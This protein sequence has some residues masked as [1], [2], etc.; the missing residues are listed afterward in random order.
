MTQPGVPIPPQPGWWERTNRIG[1]AT[2]GFGWGVHAVGVTPVVGGTFDLHTTISFGLTGAERY[3][4]TFGLSLT[5]GLGMDGAERYTR[6]LALPFT[7]AVAMAGAERYARAFNVPATP[8]IAMTGGSL[9]T[10]AFGLPF[11]PSL[12]MTAAERYAQTVGLAVTPTFGMTG[13]V[14]TGVSYDATSAGGQFTA[15][16]FSTAHTIAGKA[17]IVVVTTY[18]NQVPTITATVGATPMV[19]LYSNYYY[20]SGGNYASIYF[21]G[22]LNP[23]TGAQTISYTSSAGA[24]CTYNVGST[25]YNNAASIGAAQVASSGGGSSLPA[26]TASSAINQIVAQT[27]GGFGA[28]FTGYNQTRRFNSIPTAGYAPFVLGDAPGAAS[29]SFSGTTADIWVG[30]AVALS[31]TAPTYDATGTAYFTTTPTTTINGS[32]THTATAG[33]TVVAGIYTESNAGTVTPTGYTRS[34]TYGGTAMTSQGAIPMNNSNYGWVE[35]FTLAN[36]AGGAQTVAVHATGG[37][38]TFTIVAANSDSYLGVGSIGTAVTNY[39]GGTAMTSGSVPSGPGQLVAQIFGYVY[40]AT[41]TPGPVTAYSGSARY[42]QNNIV[43]TNGWGAMV[44]GDAPGT[45]TT[46]ITATSPTAGGYFSSVAVPLLGK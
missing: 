10:G 17:L 35:I 16:T 32:W 37:T 6:T 31:A 41:L 38:G 43:I 21:F 34:A 4:Q 30:L 42:A 13:T 12:G 20:A 33:A 29:V 23:P 22:V 19:L 14:F 45:P 26:Q 11:T 7:P 39:G 9:S 36:V 28:T 27:F 46:T 18:G 3:A 40:A 44:L 15:A 8:A 1:T 5:P 2:P 24:A 25:S